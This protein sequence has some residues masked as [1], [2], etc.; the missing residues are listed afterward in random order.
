MKN[1]CGCIR[2]SAACPIR[3]SVCVIGDRETDD[4]V[5]TGQQ[6][7]ERH[8]LD[9][10]LAH[11]RKGI[12]DQNFHAQHLGDPGKVAADAAIADDADAAAGQLPAHHHFGLPSGMVIGAG[13]RDAARQI[14]HESERE[15]GHRLDEAGSGLRDQHARVRSRL[16]VDVA[17]IDRAANEGAQL[18]QPRKNLA[19]SRGQPVGHDDFDIMRGVDQAGRIQ[20]IVAL[21]QLHLRDRLQSAQAAL[22]VILRPRLRRMGEQNFQINISRALLGFGDGRAVPILA[23]RVF[24]LLPAALD[25]DR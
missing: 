13:A 21:M 2:A 24:E 6:I 22:A 8:M 15:F 19:G 11:A 3:F 5:G 10:R 9:V 7:V 12:G 18:R 14:D 4:K 1:A 23:A 16:D 20:R 25:H 17:D